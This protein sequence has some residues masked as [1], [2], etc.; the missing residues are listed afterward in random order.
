MPRGCA[1]S[2]QRN[3]LVNGDEGI[4]CTVLMERR[5]RLQALSSV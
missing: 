5:L 2:F 4:A 1:C 3:T